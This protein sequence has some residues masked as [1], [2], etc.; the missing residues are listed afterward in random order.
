[1]IRF[2]V[3]FSVCVNRGFNSVLL[4]VAIQ[5]FQHYFLKRLFFSPLNCLDTLLKY[6]F[7]INLRIYFWTLNSVIL[8]CLSLW[9]LCL[10]CFLW[11]C[12]KIRT[13]ICVSF[14]TWLFLLKIVLANIG[15]LHFHINFR[16]SLSVSAKK[17][18]FW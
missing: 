1:M 2:W 8:T 6:Q 7:T 14:S 12:S 11:H 15:C 4:H 13:R 9:S 5:W 16:I 10:S 18:K 3:N 17:L